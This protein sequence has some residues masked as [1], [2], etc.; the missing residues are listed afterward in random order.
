MGDFEEANGF[1]A[2]FGAEN[3]FSTGFDVEKGFSAGFATAKGFK[4][5]FAGVEMFVAKGLVTFFEL[6]SAE[7]YSTRSSSIELEKGL[8][9]LE[10]ELG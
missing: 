5:G 3:G 8:F 9:K 2:G 6:A 10:F 7:F 1:S 4:T